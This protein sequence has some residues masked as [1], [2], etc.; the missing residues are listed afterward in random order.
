MYINN[1][2]IVSYNNDESK[3]TGGVV[4]SE[5]TAR[6]VTRRM[7]EWVKSGGWATGWVSTYYYHMTYSVVVAWRCSDVMVWRPFT[8]H[9]WNLTPV[10]CRW[11]QRKSSR[12][13]QTPG[14]KATA[15]WSTKRRICPRVRRSAPPYR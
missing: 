3:A 1:N 11:R 9:T 6:Y 14:R 13:R 7:K 4:Y 5:G 10:W 8:L 12:L 2:N 15:V